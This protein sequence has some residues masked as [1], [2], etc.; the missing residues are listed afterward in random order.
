MAFDYNS[1]IDF[2]KGFSENLRRT[3]LQSVVR[4]KIINCEDMTFDNFFSVNHNDI[5][6]N[7][8]NI[9]TRVFLCKNFNRSFYQTNFE[10][11]N[12]KELELFENYL[13]LMFLL[14]EEAKGSDSMTYSMTSAN[15][16]LL[17]L[18]IDEKDTECKALKKFIWILTKNV[19]EANNKLRID[20][21]TIPLKLGIA[22]SKSGMVKY[23]SIFKI[24]LF[25]YIDANLTFREKP[26]KDET[27]ILLGNIRYMISQITKSNKMQDAMSLKSFEEFI[28]QEFTET[29][30]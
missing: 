17:Y 3:K 27:R 6:V 11:E 24:N 8:C 20:N 30:A 5:R 26:A 29:L 7:D 9:E 1:D 4:K 28:A 19:H 12:F 18:Y 10:L 16:P 25:R 21:I 2:D 15:L 22:N 13:E 14:L 23:S